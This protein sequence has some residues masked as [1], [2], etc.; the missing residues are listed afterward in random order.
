MKKLEEGLHK[1]SFVKLTEKKMMTPSI[2]RVPKTNHL[3]VLTYLKESVL[4]INSSMRKIW[5]I[6]IKI[7]KP[8][9]MKRK[10]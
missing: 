9:M 7:Q 6:I 4:L 1:H 5:R 2:K 10:M 3:K 8:T